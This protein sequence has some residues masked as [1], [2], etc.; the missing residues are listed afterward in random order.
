MW[1]PDTL[2]LERT[3]K[4]ACEGVHALAFGSAN[5][6]P[7]CPLSRAACAPGGS[8]CETSDVIGHQAGPAILES[9]TPLT[10]NP[11]PFTLETEY[12]WLSPGSWD[13]GVGFEF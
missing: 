6:R 13:Q 12:L 7:L 4:V 8:I 1:N 11:N 10:L 2:S 5:P 9:H 3:D